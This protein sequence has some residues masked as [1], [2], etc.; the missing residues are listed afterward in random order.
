MTDPIIQFYSSIKS[1][2]KEILTMFFGFVF[3]WIMTFVIC[4]FIGQLAKFELERMLKKYFNWRDK[5]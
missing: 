2:Y 5:K 1:N 3:F 4:E